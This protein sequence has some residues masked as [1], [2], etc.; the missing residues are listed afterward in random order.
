MGVR[1]PMSNQRRLK[2]RIMGTA[3]ITE[4][5][6]VKNGEIVYTQRPSSSSLGSAVTVEIAFE[7]SSVPTGRDNPRPHRPWKGTVEVEGARLTGARGLNFTNPYSDKIEIDSRDPSKVHFY[8]ETRGRADK[9]LLELADVTPSTQLVIRMDESREVGGSPTLIRPRARIPAKT[10]RFPFSRLDDGRSVEEMPLGTG[11]DLGHGIRRAHL[12]RRPDGL[13]FRVRRQRP[14]R[15]GGLLL[16]ARDPT[17]R[18][19]GVVIA[20]LGRRR[21]GA[22]VAWTSRTSQ[23]GR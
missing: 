13:R 11:P 15:L 18:G 17:Q 22:V 8:T 23:P 7:S 14:G 21:G 3:P 9:M 19:A 20:D 10:L 2:A 16:R 1:L 4:A 6:V 5:S 12:R